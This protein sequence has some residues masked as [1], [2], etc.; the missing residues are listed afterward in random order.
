[1]LKLYHYDDEKGKNQSHIIRFSKEQVQKFR[2]FLDSKGLYDLEVP[3]IIGSGQ[4]RKEALNEFESQV[5]S[6]YKF[7]KKIKE[8]LDN[9]I[10]AIEYRKG[11]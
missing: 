5:D 2:M 10:D 1:M 9:G 8:D 6:Y 7:I 11:P 3:K 4:T